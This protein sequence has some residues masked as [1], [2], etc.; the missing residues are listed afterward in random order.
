M[1]FSQ[2]Q[3]CHKTLPILAEQFARLRVDKN[4]PI[5]HGSVH[6]FALSVF[7]GSILPG[8]QSSSFKR[9]ACTCPRKILGSP[10]SKHASS[11]GITHL[12]IVWSRWRTSL[13]SSRP[14]S[15]RRCVGRGLH[16]TEAALSRRGG[17]RSWR[18]GRGMWACRMRRDF[19]PLENRGAGGD[20]PRVA[21][22][23]ERD[24]S[25]VVNFNF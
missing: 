25:T 7:S 6:R 23:G 21:G 12:G 9:G 8:V 18:R 5:S 11:K 20:G 24:Y 15:R 10:L 17:S 16:R 3:F 1:L 22:E 14:G 2:A 4:G 13:E 19:V